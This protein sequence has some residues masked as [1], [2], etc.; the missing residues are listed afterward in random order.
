MAKQDFKPGDIVQLKSG[1]PPMTVASHDA[2]MGKGTVR[3]QWF[4]GKKM[5]SGYF[6]ADSLEPAKA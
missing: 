1:G 6:P 5:E 3:C 4:A 2:S